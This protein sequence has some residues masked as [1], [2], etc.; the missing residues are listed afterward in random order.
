MDT[1]PS[2]IFVHRILGLRQCHLSYGRADFGG[3]VAL[4]GDRLMALW[5]F[6]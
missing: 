6:D 4:D 3:T 2:L 5:L 1:F